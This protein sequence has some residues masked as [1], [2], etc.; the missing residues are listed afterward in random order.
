MRLSAWASFSFYYFY[1]DVALAY[2]FYC[3][4]AYKFIGWLYFYSALSYKFIICSFSIYF[5]FFSIYLSYLAFLSSSYRLVDRFSDF[6]RRRW[7][8][9]EATEHESST[10]SARLI[11]EK[12]NE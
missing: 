11:S 1:L 9:L 8:D 2:L 12:L 6:L 7:L 10:S 5:S 4:F 3:Y